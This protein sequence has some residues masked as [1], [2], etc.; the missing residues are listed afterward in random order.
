MALGGM[1]DYAGTHISTEAT[2]Y[3]SIKN[4][5]RNRTNPEPVPLVDGGGE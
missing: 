1:E 2:D 5:V 3:Q 4:Q